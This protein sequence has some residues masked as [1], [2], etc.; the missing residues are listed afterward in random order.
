MER[1]T[2]RH[3]INFF[4]QTMTKRRNFI[5]LSMTG[6]TVSN[7]II[8]IQIWYTEGIVHMCFSHT[9]IITGQLWTL[10]DCK[11]DVELG[12]SLVCVWRDMTHRFLR[13]RQGWNDPTLS[14]RLPPFLI[15][16]MS[17]SLALEEL[18]GKFMRQMP[19]LTASDRD[20]QN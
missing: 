17:G 3:P 5:Q 1:K 4:K 15:S 9:E 2:A 6:S 18:K 8:R 10:S 19:Y 7:Q 12:E 14:A 16:L 11:Q 20:S 13:Y